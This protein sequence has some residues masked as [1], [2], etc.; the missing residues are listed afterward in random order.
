MSKSSSSSSKLSISQEI[1]NPSSFNFSIPPPE[2]SPSTPVYG[3]GEMGESITPHTKLVASPAFPS[4]EVLPYSLTLVLSNKNSQNSEAQSIVKPSVDLPTEEVEVVSKAVSSTM[5]ERLFNGYL[6]KGKG[7]ESNILAVAAEL[8]AVQSLASLRGDVQPTLLEQELRSP[9]Q[10]PHSVQL[11]FDQTPKS[12]DVDNEKEE[13]EEVP[14]R[15]S[16]KDDG[17]CHEANKIQTERTR[18]RIREGH[19]PEEPTSTPLPIGSS[20]AEPDDFVVAVAKGRKKVEIERVKY[21][22]G[23]QINEE[24]SSEEGSKPTK[25]PGPHVQKQVEEKKMTKE[26]SIAEMEKQKVL[27]AKVFDPK[28]LTKFA[29]T[30]YLHEPEM[31]EFYYMME[32]LSDGGIQSIEGC[33]PSRE[34]TKHATKYGDIKCAGLPKKF[35]KG[36]YQLM[37]E[38][39]N[40]VLVPRMEKRTVAS[41][42]DLFLME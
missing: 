6:P 20:E 34:F 16:V 12:F 32:F 18:K 38:F 4:G 37:F 23:S 10:V 2:E 36:E 5:S 26:E 14:L 41:V 33:K 40:K 7:V 24:I 17:R 1:E 22:E 3:V 39:I 27:N 42:T 31:H 19:L 9:E 29:P 28:I 30:P 8:V 13:E 25:G 21:K 15:R 11:V 35:L